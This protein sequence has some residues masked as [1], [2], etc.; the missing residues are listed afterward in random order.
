MW[1]S[2]MKLVSSGGHVS[3]VTSTTGPHPKKTHGIYANLTNGL[4]K[5]GGVFTPVHPGG[6]APA[7]RFD[8]SDSTPDMTPVKTTP[9]NPTNYANFSYHVR[10]PNGAL[11]GTVV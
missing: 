8:L 4:G 5:V 7:N 11:R 2:H 9:D 3:P 10:E 1:C 6:D